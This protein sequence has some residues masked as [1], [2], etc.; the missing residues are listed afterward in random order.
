MHRV[1]TIPSSIGSLSALGGL[2]LNN[3]KLTGNILKHYPQYQLHKYY[4]G[5]GTI[6]SSISGLSS[7]VFLALDTCK[8]TGDVWVIAGSTD[9]PNIE[10]GKM[11]HGAETMWEDSYFT[12]MHT[13]Y[14]IIRQSCAWCM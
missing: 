3:N 6:P 13:H 8:L 10:I 1:G 5:A 9:I 12:K 14:L 4:H 2:S 11:R 7:V